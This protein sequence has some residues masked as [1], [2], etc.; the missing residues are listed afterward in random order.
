MLR[1]KQRISIRTTTLMHQGAIVATL[2]GTAHGDAAN[3]LMAFY[4]DKAKE[5]VA[6]GQH[7]MAAIALAFALETAVLTYLLVEFGE[8][9]GGELKIPSDVNFSDLIAAAN[10]IDVLG[11]PINVP[12]HVDGDNENEQPKFVAKDVVDKVR[13]FRNQIHPARMLKEQFDPRAFGPDQW[14]EISDMYESV[15]H[16]LLYHL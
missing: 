8:E 4:Q 10:E 1:G 2:T 6:A 5:L 12:S 7:F 9:N 3:D 16:S 11:A 15:L 14:K 13:R